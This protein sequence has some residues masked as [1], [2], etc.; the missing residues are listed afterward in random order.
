MLAFEQ[1]K[2]YNKFDIS[3]AMLSSIKLCAAE[4]SLK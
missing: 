4:G 2:R 3:R 1:F